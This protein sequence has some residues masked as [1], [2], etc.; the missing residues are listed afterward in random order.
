MARRTSDHSVTVFSAV[1]LLIAFRRDPKVICSMC[2]SRCCSSP[3]N[4]E[5]ACVASSVLTDRIS[6]P[7]CT[8][9]VSWSD[10]VVEERALVLEVLLDCVVELRALVL[11][12]LLD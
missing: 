9:S 1:A 8:T 3:M 7:C 6:E 4:L 12:V 10:C 2:D 5:E 11:E